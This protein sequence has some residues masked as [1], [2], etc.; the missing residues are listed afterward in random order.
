MVARYRPAGNLV[1]EFRDNV[2]KGN[3]NEG[4]C[5]GRGGRGLQRR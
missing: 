5:R 1:Y 4:Y 2:A 3:F